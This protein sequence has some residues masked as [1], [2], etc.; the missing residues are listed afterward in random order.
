[1]SSSPSSLVDSRV[2]A[3][4]SDAVRDAR[5][6]AQQ[7]AGRTGLFKT[8]EFRPDTGLPR[9]VAAVAGED[10]VTYLEHPKQQSDVTRIL[11]EFRRVTGTYP[12]C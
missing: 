11:A 5:V 8:S 6:F 9:S 12:A 10:G 7:V 2:V 4:R 3:G 1:M